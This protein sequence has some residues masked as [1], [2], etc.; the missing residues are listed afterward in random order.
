MCNHAYIY[1]P[2]ILFQTSYMREIKE[3][4]K[5]QVY[6]AILVTLLN[7]KAKYPTLKVKGGKVYL[8]HSSQRF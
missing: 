3:L 5:N 7:A 2:K 6:H 4:L 8:A 1:I